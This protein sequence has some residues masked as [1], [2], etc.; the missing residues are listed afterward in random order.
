MITTEQ[1]EID[2]NSN[3]AEGIF[4][5]HTIPLFLNPEKLA[6]IYFFYHF[7]LGKQKY[8]IKHVD[9]N[10]CSI[11]KFSISLFSYW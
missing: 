10:I 7:E 5:Y 11:I 6:Q 2:N 9:I 3:M 4:S 1:T 8:K